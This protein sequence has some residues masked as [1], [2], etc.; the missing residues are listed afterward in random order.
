MTSRAVFGDFLARARR[1]LQLAARS[2]QTAAP[3]RDAEEITQSLARLISVLGKYADDL[4]ATCMTIHARS[5]TELSSQARAAIQARDALASAAQSIGTHPAPAQPAS[6]A[7]RHLDAASASLTAG[8]DLLHT[9]FQSGQPVHGARYGR[10]AW[11]IVITSP[12]VSRALLAEV[13]GLSRL[14]AAAG[15]NAVP[16]DRPWPAAALARRLNMACHALSAA[17]YAGSRDPVRRNERDLLHAVPGSGLPP[18]RAPEA[19]ETTAGL[20]AGIIAASERVS[21]LAWTQ[22]Q[23]APSS[24]EISVTSW[25]RIAGAGTA[26]SH[27]CHLVLAALA[28]RARDL[29]QATAPKLEQAAGHARL[30][31]SAWLQAGRALGN[32]TTDIRWQTSQAATEAAD[33]ALWSGRLAFASPAWRPS[34]GPRHP[35][36]PPEDLAPTAADLPAVITAIHYA[37]EA[38]DRLAACTDTQVRGAGRAGRILMPARSFP[39]SADPLGQFAPVPKDHLARLCLTCWDAADVSSSAAASAGEAAV[40][41]RARSRVLVTA[42]TVNQPAALTRRRHSTLTAGPPHEP[43]GLGTDSPGP[44]ETRLQEIG[45]TSPRLLWHAAGIDQLAQQAITDAIAG[46]TPAWS[47]ATPPAAG[48][49]A[50]RPRRRVRENGRGQEPELSVS[51]CA[52]GPELE[53]EH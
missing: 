18:R 16:E 5:L 50:K 32:V 15:Q 12:P 53:A 13:A 49:K 24:P 28:I 27:H 11:A 31:R 29:G 40:A 4:I 25:R 38:L 2:R 37:T 26:A 1:E 48:R 42:R 45:V 9:H 43:A 36:R 10:S 35:A 3:G 14:A 8:R 22:A 17:A 23:V 46:R 20:C 19:S 21:H 39:G 41:V 44:V 7:A 51:P 33:L 30:S 34:D 6:R 52:A 47:A